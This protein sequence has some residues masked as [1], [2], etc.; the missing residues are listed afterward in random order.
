LMRRRNP[1]THGAAAQTRWNC[2]TAILV[3]NS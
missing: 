2:S 3:Q 1:P